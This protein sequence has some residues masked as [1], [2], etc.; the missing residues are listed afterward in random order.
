MDYLSKSKIQLI[1]TDVD[2]TL[3]TGGKY[4]INQDSQTAI[5]KFLDSSNER[6]VVLASGRTYNNMVSIV[7][8]SKLRPYLGNRLHVAA[9]NGSLSMHKRNRIVD[10]SI[11]STVV[12]YL[13]QKL[14]SP[15]F[16]IDSMFHSEYLTYLMGTKYIGDYC[17]QGG[18]VYE[19]V[20]PDKNKSIFMMEFS[21]VTEEPETISKYLGLDFFESVNKIKNLIFTPI[22]PGFDSRKQIMV[23]NAMINKSYALNAYIEH[24]RIKPE[25]VLAVGDDLNDVEMLSLEKINSVAM[26]NAKEE[27]KKVAKTVIGSVQEKGFSNMIEDIL[28][29]KF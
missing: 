21:P 24:L 17:T 7:R 6:E 16:K 13:R 14:S 29:G 18:Y 5:K 3:G 11:D 27:V 10:E 20:F 4:A 12:F 25:N 9:F 2:G 1:V 19:R 8:D 28:K 23:N 22:T 26:G 15:E